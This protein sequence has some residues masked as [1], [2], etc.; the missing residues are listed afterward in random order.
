MI[1]NTIFKL[2]PQN[3]FN[4]I[5]IMIMINKYTSSIIDK[6][7]LSEEICS[8]ENSELNSDVKDKQNY[9]E[10]SYLQTIPIG[11][12][13]QS[14]IIYED[15]FQN[16]TKNNSTNSRLILKDAGDIAA[17]LLIIIILAPCL[18]FMTLFLVCCNF[19]FNWCKPRRHMYHDYAPPLLI[20]SQ[21][22]RGY[23]PSSNFNA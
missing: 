9:T 10:I 15:R 20:R 2:F 11:N 7:C 14:H 22:H 3:S 16:H 23:H 5:L 4:I 19:V 21:S 18:V 13:N 17:W 8:V 12:N 1:R 6:T